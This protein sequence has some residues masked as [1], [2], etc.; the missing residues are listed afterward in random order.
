MQLG[1]LGDDL[2]HT[3]NG[4]EYITTLGLLGD[5][6]LHTIN[7]KEYITT[8]RLRS[9]IQKCLNHSGGRLALVELPALIGV[10]LFH[11]EKQATALVEAS[12]GNMIETQGELM[13]TTYFDSMAAEVNDL[14]QESGMMI[15]GDIA[16]QYAMSSE[17]L[18]KTIASRELIAEGSVK[19]VLKGG[20]ASWVPDVH[21]EAQQ[22]SVTAFYTQN[23]WVAYDTVKKVGITNE[24]IY[25][26][27]KFPDGIA[28]ETAF[29]APSLLLQLEAAVEEA[30]ASDSW[31]DVAPLL[32]S[33][34]TPA[35]TSALLKKVPLLSATSKTAGGGKSKSKGASAAAG[36]A[37]ATTPLVLASSCVVSQH[38]FNE[39][40]EAAN[41]AARKAPEKAISDRRAPSTELQEAANAAA[42]KAAEKAISERRAPSTAASSQPAGSASGAGGKKGAGADDDDDWGLGNK[43]GGKKGKGGAKGG[44]TKSGGAASGKGGAK[45]GG[46]AAPAAGLGLQDMET[47]VY[48]ARNELDAGADGSL[49]PEILVLP[50]ALLEY[51]KQLQAVL[52]AGADDKRRAKDAIVKNFEE[53]FQSSGYS[54]LN[55]QAVMTAGADD[56]RRVKDAIVKNFEEAFQ[57]LALY[58][59]GVD[60]FIQDEQTYA[61]LQ[62][63]VAR[64]SSIAHTCSPLITKTR[65][66]SVPTTREEWR[67]HDDERLL[68]VLPFSSGQGERATAATNPPGGESRAAEGRL[69]VHPHRRSS[70]VPFE[71]PTTASDNDKTYYC[72]YDKH[73]TE[74]NDKANDTDKTN[75]N[76]NT[77]DNGKASDY[78]KSSGYDKHNTETN[79]KASDNG[80]GNGSTYNKCKS[81]YYAYDSD[82]T[83]TNGKT[84]D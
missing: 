55:W 39:L 72:A 36:I 43:K 62:K 64:S 81:N 68:Q 25:L 77:N 78:A 75:Y 11:C 45:S 66:V 70:S 33:V 19:G 16:V 58:G 1:L 34:L 51:E 71:T 3:I 65:V 67:P 32:P 79:D 29:V 38:V 10:D 61:T 6:L 84:N 46:E 37:A 42:R 54:I 4:E 49:I 8:V 82:S 20:G 74:T 69:R 48:D 31:L 53:A 2:L 28:L 76:G 60:V 23:G 50:G 13:T 83:E 59:R 15:L 44:A 63:H 47:A 22:G 73:N 17:L 21:A 9:E 18:I 35:D 14:L 26:A 7:G 5:D 57:R 24:M 30:V 52:T 40:Q 27:G 80:N 12:S 41:A 56:K